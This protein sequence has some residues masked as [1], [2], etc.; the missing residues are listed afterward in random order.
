MQH[1]DDLYL[2]PVNIYRQAMQELGLARIARIKRSRNDITLLVTSNDYT[3]DQ[4]K[5]FACHYSVSRL[6]AGKLK[7]T[8]FKEGVFSDLESDEKSNKVSKQ[9]LWRSR[10][11][12]K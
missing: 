3:L 4:T 5:P 1:A 10:E 9:N 6:L 2:E 12:G 7:S 8:V 11:G